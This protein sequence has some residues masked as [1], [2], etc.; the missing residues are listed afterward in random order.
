MPNRASFS[1]RASPN[2]RGHSFRGI[3]D[4]N[5]LIPPRNPLPRGR[6]FRESPVQ[7]QSF[8]SRARRPQQP[9]SLIYADNHGVRY[10]AKSSHISNAATTPTSAHTVIESRNHSRNQGHNPD[11]YERIATRR[12]CGYWNLHDPHRQWRLPSIYTVGDRQRKG[13]K[14]TSNKG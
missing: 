10:A 8:P 4:P 13:N 1:L 7:D 6:S 14:K 12:S 2:S 11:R 3:N 5:E 9:T